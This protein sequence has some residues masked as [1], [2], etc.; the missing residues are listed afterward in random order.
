MALPAPVATLQRAPR[1]KIKCAGT[2]FQFLQ[3]MPPT[4]VMPIFSSSPVHRRRTIVHFHRLRWLA[5]IAIMQRE[6]PRVGIF[7][8][9]CPRTVS[10][11]HNPSLRPAIELENPSV[12]RAAKRVKLLSGVL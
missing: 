8:R 11:R 12:G 3:V 9:L 2:G 7:H 10:D 1:E 6:N 5:A 4:V